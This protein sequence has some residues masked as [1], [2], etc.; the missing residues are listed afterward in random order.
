MRVLVVDDS[1]AL[2]ARLVALIRETF[3]DTLV[4][5][6]REGAGALA[7]VAAARPELVILDLQLPGRGGLEIL[8]SLKAASRPPRVL[9]LTNHATD[10]HRRECLARGA[11]YFFDKSM[12]FERVADV[13]S[14]LRQSRAGSLGHTPIG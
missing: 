11:D 9:V 12:E 5:E 7:A 3:G 2:R 13:L 10:G 6:A 4:D 14:E 8:A 1:A